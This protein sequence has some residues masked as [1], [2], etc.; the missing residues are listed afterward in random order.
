VPGWELGAATRTKE[1]EGPLGEPI[2]RVKELYKTFGGLVAINRVSFDVRPGEIVAVIGPNGAGKTT[3]FN[4]ITGFLPPYRG[5]IFFE[6][7]NLKGLA[8]HRVASFGVARTFQDLK[9]FTNMSVI[10]N[11]M[12]GRHLQSKAGMFGTAFRMPSARKEERE[13]MDG[14]MDRLAMVGLEGEALS[15]PLSLPYGKQKML[16]I[17]RALA[18]EPK[19][20]LIDEPAGG[21]STH[22]IGELAQL[23]RQ[24]RE[25]GVTSLLVEH[26]MELVMGIADR[27]IVLNFGGKI[28]EGSPAEVQANEQVITAYLGEEF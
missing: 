9:L 5:E 19:L 6:G 15:S 21:L 23:I 28:A 14:A 26:R 17:A 12:M 24:I 27:V 10:E 1:D 4:L 2:L 22:E 7:N 25:S 3:L 13:I 20:L 16:E 18:T 8:A 11:V